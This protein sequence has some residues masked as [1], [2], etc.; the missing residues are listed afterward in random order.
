M[1]F[2]FW[3]KETYIKFY[4]SSQT[5]AKSTWQTINSM[6]R[7]IKLH[8][9]NTWNQK[10]WCETKVPSSKLWLIVTTAAMLSCVKLIKKNSHSALCTLPPITWITHK[11]LGFFSLSLYA[12]ARKFCGK[13][14]A[15]GK[16]NL[17]KQYSMGCGAVT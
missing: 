8:K 5:H 2:L 14:A 17:L 9:Q 15:L 12:Q 6:E 7:K 11:I 1:G 3:R 10:N 13:L 16:Y 4:C